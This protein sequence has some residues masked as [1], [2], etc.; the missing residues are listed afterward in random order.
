VPP[1]YVADTS[2]WIRVGRNHPPDIF[3]SLWQRFDAA[4]AAG[5]LISPDEVLHELERGTDDVAETLSN[6]GG[7]FLALDEAQMTAVVE[8]SGGS[9]LSRALSWAGCVISAASDSG[10]GKPKTSRLRGTGSRP[11]VK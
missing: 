4:I 8:V 5:D 3:V 11:L 1:P 9:C 7:L 10:R 2:I 6:R